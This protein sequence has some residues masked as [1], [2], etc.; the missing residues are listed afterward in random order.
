MVKQLFFWFIGS[1]CCL[2]AN[3][4]IT[5][6][7]VEC[8]SGDCNNGTGVA[9]LESFHVYRGEFKNGK[10]EGKGMMLRYDMNAEIPEYIGEFKKG[11]ANG[12][13]TQL[14]EGNII[15]AEGTF[16]NGWFIKGEINFEN[17]WTAKINAA[18]KDKYNVEYSGSL[19]EGTQKKTDFSNTD[20]FYLKRKIHPVTE[21]AGSNGN[22]NSNLITEIKADMKTLTDVFEKK[23]E[24]T[25]RIY[26]LY[27]ELLD[28]LPDDNYCALNRNNIIMGMIQLYTEQEA[29]DLDAM[30][31]RLATNIS[32]YRSGNITA[33]QKKDAGE[34]LKLFSRLKDQYL[35]GFRDELV[36]NIKKAIKDSQNDLTKGSISI[37]KSNA[38]LANN[39]RKESRERTF[40]IWKSLAALF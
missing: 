8:L 23:F 21:T 24:I 7:V 11:M 29:R 34:V 16:E 18:T 25:D 20:I 26:T 22:A 36:N 10:P 14:L 15:Y 5:Y 35:D 2:A 12:S 6:K 39:S 33:Q 27:L 13:G 31:F 3:A 40:E 32:Q 9:N 4:Q 19:Y 1:Y 30:V 28:C 38:R 37:M 17:K